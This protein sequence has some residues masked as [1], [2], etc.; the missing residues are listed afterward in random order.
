M[1]QVEFRPYACVQV[2]P[3]VFVC[4]FLMSVTFRQGGELLLSQTGWI[5]KCLN[6]QSCL[7]LYAF[8]GLEQSTFEK[9]TS[10]KNKEHEYMNIHPPPPLLTF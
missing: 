10:K 5:E 8:S 6:L 4:V 7:K 2:S 1:F 3:N 9:Q